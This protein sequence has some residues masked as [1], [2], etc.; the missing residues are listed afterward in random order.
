MFCFALYHKLTGDLSRSHLQRELRYI[1]KGR[2]QRTGYRW[3][4]IQC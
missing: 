2:A 4:Y 3:E 1:K